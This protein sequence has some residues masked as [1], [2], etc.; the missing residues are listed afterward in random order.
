M[1]PLGI[2]QDPEGRQLAVA[3]E[4]LYLINMLPAPGL[5]FLVLLWLYFRN[6]QAA[7]ALA[8]CHLWQAVMVSLWAG[9]LI[10]LVAILILMLEGLREPIAWMAMILYVL[11]IH[12][13]FILFGVVALVKAMAGEPYRYPLI[14]PRCA[15]CRPG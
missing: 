14:G 2:E 6:R 11:C 7:P 12:S 3:A 10:G 9:V 13:A 15:T 8:A 4:V 1:Q 5:G